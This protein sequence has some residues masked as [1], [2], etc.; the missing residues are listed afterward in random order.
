MD[1]ASLLTFMTVATLLVISP[2]PNSLLLAKTVPCLGKRAG[3]FNIVGFVTAFYLHGTLSI[4]GISLILLQSAKAFLLFKLLGASYLC[5]IGAK[6]LYQA[7]TNK[8]TTQANDK[9]M[10][11]NKSTSVGSFFEGFLTNALNPKVSI[12][13]LAAFPQFINLDN[14]L[15]SAYM[16]VSAHALINFIWFSTM[17]LMLGKLNEFASSQRFTLWLKSLSGIFFVGF[18]LKLATLKPE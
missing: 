1:L 8:K 2:G 17:V 15:S 10:G 6:N 14:S 4:F 11:K 5:W 9:F 16:L 12:F 7:F 13:Y 3:F 18:G